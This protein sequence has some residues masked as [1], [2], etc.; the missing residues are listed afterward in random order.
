MLPMEA[1]SDLYDFSGEQIE[2]RFSET[3]DRLEK[4][5]TLLGQKG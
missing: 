4:C 2:Q 3:K 5:F 1:F